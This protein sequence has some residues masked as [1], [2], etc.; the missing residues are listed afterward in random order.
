MGWILTSTKYY[1][2]K[3][4]WKINW[5]S[6]KKIFTLLMLKNYNLV[7]IQDFTKISQKKYI[8]EFLFIIILKNIALSKRN[9][10]FILKVIY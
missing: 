5:K 2:I 10:N 8:R 1:Y 3:L 7:I 4:E 9:Y 6:E